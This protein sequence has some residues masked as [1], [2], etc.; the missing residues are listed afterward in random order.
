MFI[1]MLNEANE[2]NEVIASYKKVPKP[3]VD[4]T[5]SKLPINH[6]IRHGLE[7][8]LKEYNLTLKDLHQAILAK[9]NKL[10]KDIREKDPE[11]IKA[12]EE[13]YTKLPK[14]RVVIF[15]STNR[16]NDS[17]LHTEEDAYVFDML[18]KKS[19]CLLAD[20]PTTSSIEEKHF[21]NLNVVLRQFERLSQDVMNYHCFIY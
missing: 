14:H 17:A 6:K 4:I 11:K 2:L 20:N 13:F 15:A 18:T 7:E 21:E 3:Q 9:R 8:Y 5:A 19:F 12:I 10:N 16:E 1:E